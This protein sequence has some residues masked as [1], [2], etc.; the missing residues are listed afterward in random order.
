MPLKNEPLLFSA[1]KACQHVVPVTYRAAVP[2]AGQESGEPFADAPEFPQILRSLKSSRFPEVFPLHGR[3][4]GVGDPGNDHPVPVHVPVDMFCRFENGAGF[5]QD[6]Q[7]AVS[8][9]S[10]KHKAQPYRE[11]CPHQPFCA[12]N[13][14]TVAVQLAHRQNRGVLEVSFQPLAEG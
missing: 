8:L 10:F 5:V 9:R 12:E 2:G 11:A 13:E 4:G 7:V 6:D 1:Q 14:D 3:R